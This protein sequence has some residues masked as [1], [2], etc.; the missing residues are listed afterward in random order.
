MR[1]KELYPIFVSVNTM[2]GIGKKTEEQLDKLGIKR[3]VDMLWH[4]PN[5]A[6]DRRYTPK[7]AEA[8]PNTIATL[9]VCIDKIVEP[10]NP[11]QPC[12]IHVSDLS[13]SMVISYFKVNKD[14]LRRTFAIGEVR[15]VSGTISMYH[16]IKQMAHPDYVATVD[17]L[18]YIA[19]LHPV[20]P[21]SSGLSNKLMSRLATD[22]LSRLPNFPEWQ[23]S[24][25]LQ[26]QEW[27]SFK[28]AIALLH[29][30][31]D[32]SCLDIKHAAR[33]RLAYDEILAHQLALRLLRKNISSHNGRSF[34]VDYSLAKQAIKNLPFEL[35]GAQKRS[36]KE[37]IHDMQQPERM[38]RLLQG[39]VGS[40]KTVVALFS[41]LACIE[42]GAQAAIL[43]PTEV[44]ARQH[45]AEMSKILNGIDVNVEILTGREKGKKRDQILTNLLYGSIDILIGTHAILQD[46]VKFKDLGLAVVD[47]QHKFGVQQRMSLTSKNEHVDLLVMTAT[48]IPRSLMLS[49]WG[50]MDS[51]KLDEKPSGRKAIETIAVPAARLM[52]IIDAIKRVLENNEKVYWVC[53]LVEDSE[54]IDLISAL[55]RYEWLHQY[56][57]KQNL[58]LVH[59]KMKSKEKDDIIKA[60][61]DADKGI[62]VATTVVEV[63]MDIKEA[64]IMIVEH[65]ERFGLAQLHQLR[66]RVGRNDMQSR[67]ILLYHNTLGEIAKERLKVMRQTNDGFFIAE[68]DLELR[69]SGDILGTR[70]S[71]LPKFNFLYLYEHKNLLHMASDDV[72]M[73]LRTDPKL[74]TERGKALRYLL[75]LFEKNTAL[76]LLMSG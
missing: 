19:K 49:V 51:S 57:D 22:A 2:N 5:K 3:Y 72:Q 29:N 6:I 28:D 58:F 54:L 52:E 42:A 9:K 35:T 36:I 40:G 48:P 61:K 8:I 38:V 16:G 59:G 63:G 60:F 71:G 56:F 10:Q 64:T 67:C 25:L 4:I 62:L 41:A 30:P 23:D 65:A 32:L 27:A 76:S 17:E 43:A 46:D 47:E 68:K 1:P 14:W 44:L 75:Y 26:R 37:I 73:I 34:K 53:P 7:I 12:S 55:Q 39:D 13:G 11:R 50:D 24:S 33:Q 21:L 70:Q 31:D 74:Q 20:Y 15:V 45:F 18:E 69:G 66:G